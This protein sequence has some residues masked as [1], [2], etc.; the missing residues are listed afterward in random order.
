[1]ECG[2]QIQNVFSRIF[3]YKLVRENLGWIGQNIFTGKLKTITSSEENSWKIQV[4]FLLVG[5]NLTSFSQSFLISLTFSSVG[6]FL[7]VRLVEGKRELFWCICG[8]FI[9]LNWAK[10]CVPKRNDTLFILWYISKVKI[11]VRRTSIKFLS[12]FLIHQRKPTHSLKR[13]GW[14]ARGK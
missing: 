3:Q 1:M 10:Y 9:K 8:D 4:L 11:V 14:K 7:G 13:R 6:F 2:S 12:P 5:Q